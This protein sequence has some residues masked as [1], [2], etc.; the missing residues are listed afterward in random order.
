[1]RGDFIK[2]IV[3]NNVTQMYLCPKGYWNTNL[4]YV[5]FPDMFSLRR[6]I[7]NLNA[8]FTIVRS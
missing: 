5:T 7:I 4:K 1:M 2:A 8:T 3:Q 6:E